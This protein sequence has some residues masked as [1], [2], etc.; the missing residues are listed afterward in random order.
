MILTHQ[1]KR[2]SSINIGNLV[3]IGIRM[4]ADLHILY[5]SFTVE[6]TAGTYQMKGKSILAIGYVAGLGMRFNYEFQGGR[7]IRGRVMYRKITIA[8]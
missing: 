3:G 5:S 6:P 8:I 7:R 4:E 2:E 1:M